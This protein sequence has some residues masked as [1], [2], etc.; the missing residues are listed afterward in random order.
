M[1]HTAIVKNFKCELCSSPVIQRSYDDDLE[2]MDMESWQITCDALEFH[3]TKCPTCYIACPKCS[4][5]DKIDETADFDKLL[6]N[7][8]LVKCQFLGY[9]AQRIF[10][11][12][13]EN[14]PDCS[15]G[16]YD[17]DDDDDDFDQSIDYQFAEKNQFHINF[18][19]ITAKQ[20]N[21]TGPDG[22]FP[23]YWKCHKCLTIY[24]YTDK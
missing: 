12:E 11:D 16:R 17:S 10:P 9:M 22:G 8:M 19:D 7:A 23:H 6:P 18:K 13:D 5:F 1:D 3:C 15:G 21:I 2:D 4:D 14:A 24:D 20:G